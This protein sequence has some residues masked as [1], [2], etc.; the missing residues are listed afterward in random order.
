MYKKKT[1][2][3]NHKFLKKLFFNISIIKTMYYRSPRWMFSRE[4]QR[5]G[6]VGRPAGIADV[7]LCPDVFLSGPHADATTIAQLLPR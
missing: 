2:K 6:I 1:L 3:T 4:Q 7:G 5:S